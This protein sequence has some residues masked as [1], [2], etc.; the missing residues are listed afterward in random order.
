MRGTK[1]NMNLITSKSFFQDIQ[2]LQIKL[3]NLSESNM[4]DLLEYSVLICKT[5]RIFE[6]I[7]CLWIEI[8]CKPNKFALILDFLAKLQVK[9][10]MISNFTNDFIEYKNELLTLGD[11]A[12]TILN[13]DTSKLK[14]LL[15]DNSIDEIVEIKKDKF[16]MRSIKGNIPLIHFAALVGAVNC[17]NLLKENNA[18]I[19]INVEIPGEV[20][21]IDYFA[22]AGG[23][24]SIIQALNVKY[25]KKY[26]NTTIDFQHPEIFDWIVDNIKGCLDY[27]HLNRCVKKTFLHGFHF[28]L[29]FDPQTT[30]DL[31]CGTHYYS[32]VTFLNN[33]YVLQPHEGL[34][35][36]CLIGD[37][38][39]VEL[40]LSNPC[41]N[42][43]VVIKNVNPLN[44]AIRVKSVDIIIILLRHDDINVNFCDIDIP[45][46][47]I[48]AIIT[49]FQKGIDLLLKHPKIDPNNISPKDYLHPLIVSILKNEAVGFS[50][51]LNHCKISVNFNNGSI[52]TL[53]AACLFN[54]DTMFFKLLMQRE[55]LNVNIIDTENKSLFE[56]LI[57]NG[58][59]ELAT[60]LVKHKSFNIAKGIEVAIK[61]DDV[62]LLDELLNNN[63]NWIGHDGN[64]ILFKCIKEGKILMAKRIEATNDSPTLSIDQINEMQKSITYTQ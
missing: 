64:E 28:F 41:A 58:K 44:T 22:I 52:S 57:E 49:K 42:V 9:I 40:L 12:W 10:P 38:K 24:F 6:L 31:A 37:P 13:D 34:I 16:F 18:D 29:G 11:V 20:W 51:L 60:L 25:D 33:N 54:N 30:F 56:K 46:P 5:D 14:E 61:F 2:N 62:D 59:K 48:C 47:L 26:I 21:S 50:L 23:S 1:Q 27:N 35:R 7:M 53:E 4:M 55:D 45:P 3:R 8:K 15:E 39:I 17:F 43:N 36:A 63:G 32:L 19:S